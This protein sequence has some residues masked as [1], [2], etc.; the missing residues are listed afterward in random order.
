MARR[1]RRKSGKFTRSGKVRSYPL[2]QH[3][4]LNKLVGERL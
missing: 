4:A 3:R 1:R 2:A